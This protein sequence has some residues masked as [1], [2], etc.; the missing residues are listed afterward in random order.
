MLLCTLDVTQSVN[1]DHIVLYRNSLSVT[2][3]L[4]GSPLAAA[5]YK[6]HAASLF[7]QRE[8]F[9]LGILLFPTGNGELGAIN[10]HHIKSNVFYSVLFII[11]DFLTDFFKNLLCQFKFKIKSNF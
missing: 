1:Q 2:R 9:R 8:S 4:S 7:E 10:Y 3:L 5:Q 11:Q 6:E